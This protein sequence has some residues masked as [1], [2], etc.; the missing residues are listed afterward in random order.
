MIERNKWERTANRTKWI[1]SYNELHT[2]LAVKLSYAWIEQKLFSFKSISHWEFLS[3]SKYL[4]WW[5]SF[6]LI[7][8]LFKH[9]SILFWTVNVDSIRQLFDG[10]LTL[11][12]H[13][14]SKFGYLMIKDGKEWTWRKRKKNRNYR[15]EWKG[16]YAENEHSWANLINALGPIL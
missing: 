10:K 14:S 15:K 5:R 6:A 13:M 16:L 12:L 9:I 2:W 11:N 1:Q 3:F 8:L 4:S 7:T